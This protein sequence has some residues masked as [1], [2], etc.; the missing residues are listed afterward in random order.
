MCLFGEWDLRRTSVD[1]CGSKVIDTKLRGGK[2]DIS[3]FTMI[4]CITFPQPPTRFHWV[5]LGG[6]QSAV[7]LMR[8]SW[9]AIVGGG[10][11]LP[12]CAD[13]AYWAP[14]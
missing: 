10:V 7:F 13:G 14:R 1:S 4:G 12:R 2:R 5:I 9:G 11:A 8:G 3:R 6:A